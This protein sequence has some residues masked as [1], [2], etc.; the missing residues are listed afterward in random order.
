ACL[1]HFRY[2]GKRSIARVQDVWTCKHFGAA[3]RKS[4]TMPALRSRA[5]ASRLQ[6][7]S[8]LESSFTLNHSTGVTEADILHQALLEGNCSTEVSLTVLDTISFFTQ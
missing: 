5:G 3:D 6:H 8:S 2:V 1:F 7:L 4:Q